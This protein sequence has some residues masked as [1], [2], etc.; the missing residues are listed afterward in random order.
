MKR[1]ASLLELY[2]YHQPLIVNCKER[3][4][5]KVWY[6]KQTWRCLLYGDQFQYAILFLKI[7]A[8]TTGRIM[9]SNHA[10]RWCQS[11]HIKYLDKYCK[12]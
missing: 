11:P 2:L 7:S 1:D 6:E 8:M 10:T 3:L 4:Y 9:A 12:R 5:T